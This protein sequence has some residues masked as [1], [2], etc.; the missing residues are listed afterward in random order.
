MTTDVKIADNAFGSF[1]ADI[2]RHEP[3][4]ERLRWIIGEI[5]PFARHAGVQVTEVGPERAVVEIP[6][7]PEMTNQMGT[8]HA[9]ALF[10]AADVAGAVAFIGAVMP[11]L[12]T[13]KMLVLRNAYTSFRKPAV[14]R[15]RAVATVDEREMRAV[16]AATGD[17]R[18]D[19]NGKA[20]LYDDAG[21]LVAK[22]IFDYVADVN[23]G[24]DGGH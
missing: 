14:G 4:Y 21:T 5:V 7:A 9:G 13:V 19:L 1:F 10:L 16:L 15:I 3:D 22:L 24:S 20:M 18:F 8:V 23:A 12:D 17:E 11:R 6:D 2:D